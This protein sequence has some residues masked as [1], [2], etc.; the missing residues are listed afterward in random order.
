MS[1]AIQRASYFVADFE[2]Q[3][4]WFVNEAGAE[5]ARRFQ[6]ALDVSLLKLSNQPDLG[7]PRHFSHPKLRGLR[8]YPVERPFDKLLIFY[9]FEDELL[10][11]VRL[12]HSARDLPRR[13]VQ[14]P[15]SSAD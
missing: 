12:M 2:R 10:R 7:R 3:F 8:S 14:P 1:L 11:A 13:L 6:S 15:G 5:I 4:G 9:R